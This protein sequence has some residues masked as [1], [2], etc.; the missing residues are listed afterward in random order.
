MLGLF[1]GGGSLYEGRYSRPRLR[2]RLPRHP[3]R[4][5]ADAMCLTAALVRSTLKQ[6]LLAVPEALA[7]VS[8]AHA[9]VSDRLITQIRDPLRAFVTGPFDASR[10]RL[11][12]QARTALADLDARQHRATAEQ[13]RYG[14]ECESYHRLRMRVQDD[15]A[16]GRDTTPVLARLDASKTACREARE[17]YKEAYGQYCTAFQQVVFEQM[18]LLLQDLH[19]LELE[20]VETARTHLK[21]LLAVYATII[22]SVQQSL[23][24]ADNAVAHVGAVADIA[25]FV[26]AQQSRKPDQPPV[27]PPFQLH[28]HDD[29]YEHISEAGVDMPFLSRETPDLAALSTGGIATP[30]APT[31][32]EPVAAARLPTPPTDT[33]PTGAA[34]DPAPAVQAPCAQTAVGTDAGSDADGRPPADAEPTRSATAPGSADAAEIS[35]TV[36]LETSSR[37]DVRT[38]VSSAAAVAP[39]GNFDDIFDDASDVA[40]LPQAPAARTM[41]PPSPQPQPMPSVSTATER[42][43]PP[44]TPRDSATASAV[45][46]TTPKAPTTPSPRPDEPPMQRAADAD[47]AAHRS[48]TKAP[49]PAAWGDVLDHDD[50]SDEDIFAVGRAARQSRAGASPRALTGAAAEGRSSTAPLD[51]HHAEALLRSAI[52]DQPSTSSWAATEAEQLAQEHDASHPLFAELLRTA[53]RNDFYLL[54]GLDS[55]QLRECRTVPV[56]EINRRRRELAHGDKQRAHAIPAVVDRTHLQRLGEIYGSVFQMPRSRALYDTVRSARVVSA[57]IAATRA[58]ADTVGRCACSAP[59]IRACWRARTRRLRRWSRVLSPCVTTYA[60]RDCPPV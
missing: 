29:L 11:V 28:E 24:S 30:P 53:A 21:Q 7:Q 41:P 15:R 14:R 1:G 10:R 47:T 40:L 8:A 42:R 35:P 19:K 37:A 58:A 59:S 43:S 17:A 2:L 44:V 39:S 57:A 31:T 50:G 26:A 23:E 18:P 27:P 51:P 49:S 32:P 55:S 25:E 20:R 46:S 16:A 45:A 56:E 13:Q 5:S 48:A 36:G 33:A 22:P 12:S 4:A 3:A 52:D 38:I 9:A 34:S 6:A 60:V 54:F